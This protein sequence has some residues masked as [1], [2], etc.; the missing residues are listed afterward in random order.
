M[1]IKRSLIYS[2]FLFLY[3]IPVFGQVYDPSDKK[4]TRETYWLYGSLQRLIGAGVIFGHHDDL[5]YGVGW[6]GDKDRSDVKSVTGSY[7]AL[8]GWDLSGLEHNSSKDINIIPFKQ[9]EKYVKEVYKRGGINTFCWH[10]NNPV[11]G[12]T[13]WD[14]SENTVRQIISGGAYHEAYIL[15]LDRIAKYIKKLKG[16]EGE[17]IPILFRPFHELTG[18]WFWWCKNTCSADEFKSLWRFTIDYLRNTKKLHNLLVVYSVADFKS[19]EAFLERYPGDSYVDVVGFDTYCTKSVSRYQRDFEKDLSM[20]Q[21][22]AAEHH[23]LIAVAETGYEHLPQSDWWTTVLLPI[24]SKYKLSY[25]MVWRNAGPTQ[26][27]APYPGQASA[28]DFKQFFK[29]EQTMFQNRITGMGIYGK[30]I[31]P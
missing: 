28:D 3:T 22:I 26:F 19:K 24:T 7:P 29:S 2:V 31:L 11:N 14:T 20:T 13:A 4:A 1:L 23:K 10:L 17:P 12:K 25:L 16:D 18:N 15:Y 6:R 9:Q 30:Y 27:Y 5:A 21:D 8:Y